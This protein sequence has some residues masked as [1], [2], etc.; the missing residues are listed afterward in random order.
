MA[1][2]N[3]RRKL[4]AI[5]SADVDGYSRLMGD[6]EV[7]T[8]STLKSHRNLITEKVQAFKGRVV[9]SPGDNILSELRSIVDAVS[10]A[11]AIQEGLRE[12]NDK[13]PENRKMLFRI[14]V[15]LGDVIQDEDRIYGDGVNIAA[16]VEGLAKPGEVAISGTAFDNIR[17]KLKVG[18]EF[19][20]EHQVKNIAQPVRVYRVLTDPAS[21]G[22]II[23]E[24]E[25]DQSTMPKTILAVAVVILIVAAAY[26]YIANKPTEE[27]SKKEPERPSIA[28]LPFSN[29]SD[30]PQQEY[31]SDGMTDDLITDLSKV[32]GL[33]VISRNSTFT[34]K[35]KPVQIK[36]VAQELGVK[37][38]LEGSVRKVGDQIRINAQLIDA[39]KDHH[40]WA[41][42]YDGQ[43][44]DVFDL[45]DRITQ[46]IV[47]AL[48]VNLTANEKGGQKTKET[49]NIQ[50]YDAFLKGWSYFLQQTREEV[51]KAIPH[52]KKAIEI[53]PEYSRAYAAL[54]YVYWRSMDQGWR[55]QLGVSLAAARLLASKYLDEAMKR[56]NSTAY[57]L[58]AE[59]SDRN[60]LLDEA[61]SYAQKA[62]ALTPS[63]SWALLVLGKML[64]INGR[65]E[66]G[67]QYLQKSLDHDPQNPAQ[68]WQYQAL[69]ESCLGNYEKAVSLGERVREFNPTTTGI[70]A[71]LSISYVKIGQQQKAE[72]A[73]AHYKKGWPKWL[74]PTIPLVMKFFNVVDPQT[75]AIFVKSLVKAGLPSEPSDYVKPWTL[76]RLK[77]AEIKKLLLGK[78]IKGLGFYSGKQ[79]SWNLSNE[80]TF[81]TKGGGFGEETGSF[82][83]ENDFLVVNLPK[84]TEG[85]DNKGP[86]FK[87]KDG[88][89]DKSNE[90]VFASV[91]ALMPFSVEKDNATGSN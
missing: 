86:V 46:Q 68:V 75:S 4:T 62:V 38:V 35:G 24:P 5:L 10:C 13:L 27:I 65:Y 6:D 67:F 49:K 36:S 77:D 72:E 76:V 28:V 58:A 59:I 63:D 37:Y 1:D 57:L 11:V 85:L 87:N 81:Q 48:A 33:M 55:K 14:G 90:Y 88:S 20:G 52:L 84:N 21:S 41:E 82:K 73:F 19:V 23:G 50:A 39:E 60:F 12:Q 80:G 53:D 16:R 71:I 30:D 74:P 54:A 47:T 44:D 78:K 64:T 61:L 34:Y 2:E 89:A 25:G 70:G 83:I 45:Q 51:P 3:Y 26:L 40:V 42:R 56:P 31:F 43:M 79:W 66:E 7:V 91:W 29:M 18:F 15:N 9:D 22:K 17:N 32:A 69:A 8:V